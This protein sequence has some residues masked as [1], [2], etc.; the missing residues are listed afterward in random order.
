MLDNLRTTMSD[1]TSQNGGDLAAGSLEIRQKMQ[2]LN[3]ND[4]KSEM[5]LSSYGGLPMP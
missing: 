5:S 3:I 2:I 4:L 1:E